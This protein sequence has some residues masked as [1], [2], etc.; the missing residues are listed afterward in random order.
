M[1][2]DGE[3]L[4]LSQ[5]LPVL[6]MLTRSPGVLIIERSR[7]VLPQRQELVIRNTIYKAGLKAAVPPRG[8]ALQAKIMY[9][10]PVRVLQQ[11]QRVQRVQQT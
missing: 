9:V 10:K 7:R 5:D 6:T 4:V 8:T 11:V 1:G 3:Q 2:M